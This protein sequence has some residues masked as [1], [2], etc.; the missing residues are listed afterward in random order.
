M[1]QYRKKERELSFRRSKA[2]ER[3]KQKKERIAKIIVP[4]LR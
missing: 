4:Y 2:T 3:K 1:P